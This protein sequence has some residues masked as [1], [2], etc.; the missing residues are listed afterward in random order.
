MKSNEPKL[1]SP[2]SFAIVLLVPGLSALEVKDAKWGL[3]GV[4]SPPL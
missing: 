1:A 4:S 3:M 2:H